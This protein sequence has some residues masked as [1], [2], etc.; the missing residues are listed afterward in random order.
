MIVEQAKEIA[1]QV[2]GRLPNAGEQLTVY[3]DNVK[4]FLVNW[5]GRKF[6]LF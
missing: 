1:M 5:D 3:I 2:Y 4:Y 6:L